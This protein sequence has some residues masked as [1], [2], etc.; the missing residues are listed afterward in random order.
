MLK[1][2]EGAKKDEIIEFKSTDTPVFIGRTTKCKVRFKDSSLS[3]TQCRIDY[4]NKRWMVKDGDGEKPSTNSTWI[5]ASEEI[6]LEDKMIIKAGASL[7][8]VAIV[9]QND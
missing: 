4:V 5:F 7:F 3:R 8:Q 1:F 6:R 2:I 9:T